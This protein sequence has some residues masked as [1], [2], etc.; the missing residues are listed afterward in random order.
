M[1]HRPRFSD[2]RSLCASP[3]LLYTPQFDI[4]DAAEKRTFVPLPGD[5][6]HSWP[7]AWFGKN[8]RSLDERRSATLARGS[9]VQIP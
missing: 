1:A 6:L 3:V 2:T 7:A 4:T 5:S 9:V 8:P